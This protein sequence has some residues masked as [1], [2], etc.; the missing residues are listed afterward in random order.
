MK[1]CEDS[2]AC[3]DARAQLAF[4]LD[5]ELKGDELAA[6]EAHIESCEDC[7]RAYEE[8]RSFFALVRAARP[9]Y[10]APPELRSRVERTLSNAPAPYAASPELRKR[11]EQ[12]IWQASASPFHLSNTRRA[13]L[14]TLTA[15]FV[16]AAFWIA[17]I[18]KD[19][20]PPRPSEFAI[21]AV[22]THQHFLQGNL[23]LE[24]SS[25]S[26]ERISAWFTGKVPFSV[27]LPS[28][29]VSGQERLY[30][31]KGGRLITF[32]KHYTA[33]VAYQ[34]RQQPISLVVTANSVV[35]PSG[36]EELV[37]KGITFHYDFIDGYKVM[38]WS[39]TGLTYALVSDLEGF[40]QESCMVCHEGMKD[41]DSIE[42][43]KPKGSD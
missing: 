4:Y 7:G 24:V 41:H 8:E 38:T 15:A 27:E 36:G 40:G 2:R 19:A 16:L 21:M 18:S 22:E 23:P 17:A 32:N 34:M 39:H 29:E 13:L 20:T 5:E 42:S 12:S 28:Q 11:V 1:Q 35:M 31:L 14:L 30:S 43:L 6:F 33:Y 25:A 10:V 3:E 9:L 37:S 26:R